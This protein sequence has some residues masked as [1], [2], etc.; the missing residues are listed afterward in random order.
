MSLVCRLEDTSSF[1]RNEYLK[2]FGDYPFVSI[3]RPLNHHNLVDN[4]VGGAAVGTV[5]TAPVGTAV[6]AVGTAVDE[7]GEVGGGVRNQSVFV[8]VS[9]EQLL[10]LS[11]V[12]DLEDLFDNAEKNE[13]SQATS[14]SSQPPQ[15]RQ[16]VASTNDLVLNDAAKPIN[17]KI[18]IK[19]VYP[20]KLCS[21][22]KI[23]PSGQTTY[24]PMFIQA[25]TDG[26]FITLCLNKADVRKMLNKSF[27]NTSFEKKISGLN[28]KLTNLIGKTLEAEIYPRKQNGCLCWALRN[29]DIL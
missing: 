7:V 12:P 28:K 10:L 11:D 3:I 18:S 27:I 24:N 23:E 8:D 15:K 19:L 9:S 13:E 20:S 14:T 26:Q 16:K 29:V 22:I 17:K 21:V 1:F 2:N 6:A 4:E 5:D 25:E